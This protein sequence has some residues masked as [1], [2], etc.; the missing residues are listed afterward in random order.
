MV[1]LCELQLDPCRAALT[2]GALLPA[3]LALYEIQEKWI[4]RGSS[5]LLA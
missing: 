4:W 1:N 3:L 5:V 2:A